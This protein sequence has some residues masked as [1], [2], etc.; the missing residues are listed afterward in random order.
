MVFASRTSRDI[1]RKAQLMAKATCHPSLC[2]SVSFALL[3][4]IFDFSL[5]IQFSRFSF[6]FE[7]KDLTQQQKA[8]TRAFSSRTPFL[9]A[10]INMEVAVARKLAALI[11]F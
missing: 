7:A 4:S 1:S 8:S 3:C 11:Q 2:D 5:K 6:P 10:N 9:K